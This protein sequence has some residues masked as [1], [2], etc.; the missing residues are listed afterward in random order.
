MR[1][2]PI[3]EIVLLW[4]AG[5][6]AAGQFAKIAVPFPEVAALYF[7][8]VALEG[9]L[10]SSISLVGAILGLS[11]STSIAKFGSERT[12]LAGM[13]IGGAISLLQSTGINFSW[14]L[15]SRV[16]EGVSHIM[17]VVAAPTLIARLAATHLQGPA[18]ALWSTFFGVSFA[19]TALAGM[20]LVQAYGPY[21]L[22]L[23]HGVFTLAITAMLKVVLSDQSKALA[24][25]ES[26][27]GGHNLTIG[28]AYIRAFSSSG[29]AAP[30]VGW[31]FYTLTF[32][33]LLAVLPTLL[34]ADLRQP[35]AA[36]M[37]L[38][39]ITV[40]L[41]IAPLLLHSQSGSTVA[42]IGFFAALLSISGLIFDVPLAFIAL[43]IFASFGLVQSGSFAAV[44]EFNRSEE[45]RALAYGLIAQAGNTGNLV[46]TPV[47]LLI[48][49]SHG[50]SAML[51]VVAALYVTAI[52][53][54]IALRTGK[55]N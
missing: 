40:S 50:P 16:F 22:F 20:P 24:S 43:S 54:S 30:G 25:S 11:A 26:S 46:G 27:T 35:I 29:I 42:A 7:Q 28:R 53:A 55:A 33:A 5:L 3:T 49:N 23:A 21:A 34:Q 9:W 32:V 1:K 41:L 15:V 37:P 36:I 31:F 45:D 2:Q 12:L 17:V 47:L 51:A 13:L 6:A 4:A 44:P 52:V 18:M 10:L 19:V 8:S 48:V 14:M 39:G 38:L